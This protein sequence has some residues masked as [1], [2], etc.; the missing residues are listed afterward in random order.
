MQSTIIETLRLSP[1]LAANYMEFNGRRTWDLQNPDSSMPLL[2]GLHLDYLDPNFVLAA[3]LPDITEDDFDRAS[4]MEDDNEPMDN[5]FYNKVARAM[6][7]LA[8]YHTD[9]FDEAV[10]AAG[11]EL[12]QE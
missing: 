11:Q 9:A 12:E 2:S 6:L 7:N 3:L 1:R 10:T 5:A 4:S 8:K